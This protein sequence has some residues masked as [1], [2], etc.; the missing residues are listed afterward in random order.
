MCFCVG[1]E[2]VILNK[3]VQSLNILYYILISR[4]VWTIRDVLTQWKD[5]VCCSAYKKMG[6]DSD[7]E[8]FLGLLLLQFLG[9]WSVW[10]VGN[11]QNIKLKVCW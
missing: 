6:L 5:I 9:N 7:P 10:A 2:I 8:S 1:G 4:N 3:S 11:N